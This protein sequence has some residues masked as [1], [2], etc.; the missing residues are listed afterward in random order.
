MRLRLPDGYHIPPHTHPK[1]ERVTVIS[2]TFKLAMGDQL[3]RSKAQTLTAGAYGFWP[4]GMKHAAWAEAK[5]SSSSTASARG[6]SSISIPLT[7]RGTRRN[8]LPSWPTTPTSRRPIANAFRRTAEGATRW[9]VRRRIHP[10]AIS[11]FSVVAALAAAVCFWQSG[12]PLR[13]CS[14]SRRG[15]ATCGSGATCSTAWSRSLPARRA[16]AAR[17]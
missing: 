9:C 15:S 17:S 8:S 10:D 5:R 7:I 13:G 2:G 12:G 3:D 11:Y 14:S 1:T 4:A 16:G 6:R